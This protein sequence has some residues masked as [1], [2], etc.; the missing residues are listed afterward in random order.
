MVAGLRKTAIRVR[1]IYEPPS[2][3]DGAR[4]L[5]DRL[6]PR[7][8]RKQD[9]RIDQWLK[10]LAP[11]TRLRK[12]FGHRPERWNEFR[13][14]YAVE[15]RQQRKEL[16][17]IRSLA[18][19]RRVTLLF[20]AHDGEHNNAIALRDVLIRGRGITAAGRQRRPRRK[21]TSQAA[22]EIQNGRSK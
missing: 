19:G 11:S 5:I 8:L 22:H 3:S 12:W 13:R 1:R 15:L 4:L 16:R 2:R 14:R 20:S 7:G 17:E 10:D 21:S 6:W 18:Q 9:A